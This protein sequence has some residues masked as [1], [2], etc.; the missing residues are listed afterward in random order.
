[1]QDVAACLVRGVAAAVVASCC[2][3]V[4]VGGGNSNRWN[5]DKT[6][7]NCDT[8]TAVGLGFFISTFQFY[9]NRKVKIK[10]KW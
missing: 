3:C 6:V 1:M 2:R 9:C 7:T 10:R 5:R 8:V 4:P